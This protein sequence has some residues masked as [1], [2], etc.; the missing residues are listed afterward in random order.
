MLLS[1]GGCAVFL[2]A[3]IMRHTSLEYICSTN[4]LRRQTNINILNGEL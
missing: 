4:S 1:D 3:C 2:A